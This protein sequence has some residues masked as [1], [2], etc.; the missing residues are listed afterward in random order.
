[1][2]AIN[3][4]L[5]ARPA[6]AGDAG[7]LLLRVVAGSFML[8]AHGWGKLADFSTRSQTFSDPF[9]L[10]S[11]LS[12]ALAVFAEVFCA[13]FVMAGVFTRFAVVPLLVT[14]LTAAFIAHAGDP[15]AKQELPLL[16]AAAYA[17]LLFAGAGRFSIDGLLSRKAEPVRVETRDAVHH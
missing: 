17:T 11:E 13:A 6:W 1:M 8:F 9:G 4:F 12:L 16:F 2:H 14:M 15:W 5:F 7:L 10:G 3:R